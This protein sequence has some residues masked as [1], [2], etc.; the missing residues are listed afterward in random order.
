MIQLSELN[1][2]NQKEFVL[3]LGT[4]FENS[5]WVAE[6]VWA[7]RPFQSRSGLHEAMLRMIK[8]LPEARLH[9]FYCLHPDLATKLSIGEYS[10]REQQGAG[11]IGYHRRNLR[12]L[13]LQINSIWSN[14]GFLS[15]TPCGA[16]ISRQFGQRY[17][18]ALLIRRNM[19]RKKR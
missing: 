1:E 5:P 2:M 18:N 11:L 17:R 4:V 13:P 19:S 6:G 14:S 15:Y 10:T 3:A 16:A 8:D 12:S 9:A 7:L